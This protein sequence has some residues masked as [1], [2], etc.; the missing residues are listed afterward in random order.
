MT[1]PPTAPPPDSAS[2][3]GQPPMTSPPP[4][5][6]HLLAGITALIE[7][8]LASVTEV[9]EAMTAVAGAAR[10]GRRPMRRADLA[11]LRPLV[12]QVLA[13]HRGFAAGAGWCW[14]RTRW[15]TRPAAS[16]G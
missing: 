1:Q 16:T 15:R 4:T 6:P 8:V 7:R 5:A 3:D 10:A 13:R 14:R 11:T 9:A 2:P 12:A